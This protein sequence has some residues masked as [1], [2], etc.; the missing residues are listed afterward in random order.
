MVIKEILVLV[1]SAWCFNID[2]TGV[3]VG[4]SVGVDVD[5]NV[6]WP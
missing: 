1:I 4:V 2:T 6:I 3:G 5:N